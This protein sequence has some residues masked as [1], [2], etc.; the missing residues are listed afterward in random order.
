MPNDA[1][2]LADMT[3]GQHTP[4]LEALA[5]AIPPED[6]VLDRRGVIH[7][8]VLRHSAHLHTPN[9][10]AIHTADLRRLFALYDQYWFEHHCRQTLGTTP[11]DFRLSTRMTKAGG[12]TTR[13]RT[14]TGGVRYEIAIACGLLFESFG[15]QDRTITVCGLVCTTRLDALQRIVEHE[16]VH[17][18]EYLCWGASD[19]SKERFQQIARAQFLH[20]AHTHQ[21][22]TRRERAA[23]AGIR[24]GH[25]VTFTFE[26]RSY[27]G[28]VNRITKRATVLVEDP[29]GQPFSDGRRYRAFYVPIQLLHPVPQHQVHSARS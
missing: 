12:S 18:I 3:V 9:F 17:L 7:N 4:R 19:C 10:T 15:T 2:R 5:L 13:Y 29:T 8:D 1:R 28:I 27:A 11:L 26:G 24:P 22:I 14:H 16:L 23:N 25:P 20:E 21:L 6:V